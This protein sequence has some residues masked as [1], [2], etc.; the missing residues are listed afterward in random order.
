MTNIYIKDSP[1]VLCVSATKYDS[2]IKSAIWHFKFRDMKNYSA[3]LSQ[4]MYLAILNHFKHINFHYISCVPL[5][6]SKLKSR[7]YNQSELLAK[8]L[9]NKLNIT[10][11]PILY[12][13]KN[14]LSQHELSFAE[15]EKNIK[16]VYSINR[17]IHIDK[18]KNLLLCDD[19]ITTGNT[20]KECIKALKQ[21]GFN[22]IYCITLAYV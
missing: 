7:G 21:N 19:I 15:R 1:P 17:N 3:P 12:K 5:H 13:N 22:N 9:A 16:G 20:L 2:Y 6:K 11:V 8:S 10:F 14:N 18:N 4:E